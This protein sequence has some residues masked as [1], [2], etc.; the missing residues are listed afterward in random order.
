MHTTFQEFSD[1][2]N[3]S[4]GSVAVE[5]IVSEF[6]KWAKSLGLEPTINKSSWSEDV[7]MWVQ[8]MGLWDL[9]Y[10]KSKSKGSQDSM[11]R[12]TYNTGEKY[13]WYIKYPARHS[14]Y[15]S[16]G[17]VKAGNFKTFK[18]LVEKFLKVEEKFETVE[19]FLR[20]IDEER[21]KDLKLHPQHNVT[22]QGKNLGDLEATFRIT[23]DGDI[24]SGEK[25]WSARFGVDGPGGGIKFNQESFDPESGA[26][27]YYA[28]KCTNTQRQ[29]IEDAHL[30]SILE[31]LKDQPFEK[32]WNE[33]KDGNWENLKS[34]YRGSVSGKKY[35]I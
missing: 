1:W 24:T 2:L 33:L 21:F 4:E 7:S 3:E 32:V 11:Y 28:M 31:I 30:L 25:E 27:F 15:N 20:M 12:Q 6:E 17:N 16:R 10:E 29:R 23:G 34:K 18:K 5:K 35:N 8:V 14:Q 9:H 26:I 13:K 22:Y 19:K